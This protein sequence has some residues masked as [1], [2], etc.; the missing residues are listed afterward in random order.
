MSK[1]KICLSEELQEMIEYNQAQNCETARFRVKTLDVWIGTIING[2]SITGTTDEERMK[3][4]S[5]L[6]AIKQDYQSLIVE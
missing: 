1:P 2:H 4:L 6:H 5:F 3:I